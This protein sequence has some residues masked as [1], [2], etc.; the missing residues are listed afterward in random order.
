MTTGARAARN[1]FFKRQ[2]NLFYRLKK[3]RGS[4]LQFI[5][6]FSGRQQVGDVWLVTTPL[7]LGIKV[8]QINFECKGYGG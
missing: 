8:A 2:C 4:S 1:P 3:Y 5:D 6:R 7:F